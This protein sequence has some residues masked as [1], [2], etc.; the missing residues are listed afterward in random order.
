MRIAGW[1]V[2]VVRSGRRPRRAARAVSVLA[3]CGLLLLSQPVVAQVGGAVPGER[4]LRPGDER[5]ALPEFRERLAPVL[6]PLPTLPPVPDRPSSGLAVFV[7]EIRIEGNTAFSDRELEDVA[8]PF[9]GRSISTE[10]LL[11]LRD[12]L[13]RHYTDAG[14]INSGAVIP[15]QDV[16]D[17]VITVRIVEGGL[18]EVVVEGLK[19]LRPSYVEGRIRSGAGRVLNALHLQE[20]LQLLLAEPTVERLD[21][22]LGPGLER[23]QS[24]LEVELVEAPRFT[25][26][27]ELDNERS[28][29]V[30]EIRG[31][32]ELVAR[33][34]LGY[35]DPLAVRA[36]LTEGLRDIEAGYSVPLTADD[37]RLRLFGEFN[38]AE[39]VEEPFDRLDIESESW[40][41]EVGLQYPV[42]RALDEQ[43]ILGADLSRRHSETS[44]LGAPFPD[45]RSG[46]S[47]VTA[48]RLIG[49]WLAR[50]EDEVRAFR[51]TVSIGIDAFDATTETQGFD[52]DGQFLA[53]LAQAQY[54]RR[55]G[56]A[57][58]QVIVR[59]DL[60]LAA[61][62]L[63]SLEQLA[64]GGLDT[65]RGY[66]ENEVVRDNGIIA[67]IEGRIPTVELRI[68]RL[69][70]PNDDATLFLAPFADL[71]HGF[72]H[73]D[74]VRALRDDETLASLGLGLVWSPA[75]RV[76][77]RL[78]YG[79]ALNEVSDPEDEGLQDHGIHFELRIGLF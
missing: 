27:F 60:Q 1:G 39:V 77:T 62:P 58:H 19:M 61:D 67:S 5:P 20:E 47:D 46:E 41:L 76:S 22:R 6:P 71:A 7:R 25:A 36:G 16:E 33:S 73:D 2:W 52:D 55:L 30:G 8:A 43:L 23:G 63:L 34:V 54:A 18:D 38:D 29:S 78:Y 28:P 49:D 32:L 50:G 4:G 37:L 79:Y 68:P 65:V 45:A 44:L 64:I 72:D 74:R 26:A 40:T 13:S 66:R 21:A 69:T 56:D 42:L 57:G 48:I 17:G 53:W 14:Y 35:G 24:R 31:E 59:A 75:P 15:D 9:V 10:E 12:R 11:E 70:G 3:T 51:S